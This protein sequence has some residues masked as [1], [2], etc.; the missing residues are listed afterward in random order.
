MDLRTVAIVTYYERSAAFPYPANMEFGKTQLTNTGHPKFHNAAKAMFVSVDKIAMA[1]DESP[2]SINILD[3]NIELQIPPGR[4]VFRYFFEVERTE[5]DY[6]GC[7]D[8]TFFPFE[9]ATLGTPNCTNVLPLTY[10]D[11]SLT[12]QD[13]LRKVID[14][15]SINEPAVPSEDTSTKY[16]NVISE[17]DID[18]LPPLS[19]LLDIAKVCSDHS[20]IGDDKAVGDMLNSISIY[21]TPLPDLLKKHMGGL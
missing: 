7:V 17:V 2:D 21:G 11:K 5:D 16:D 1:I 18:R 19:F 20:P 10:A 3:T 4:E 13:Y 6:Y 8:V 12:P 15:I 14:T 9:D